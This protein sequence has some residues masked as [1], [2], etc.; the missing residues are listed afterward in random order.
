M[1]T[2][3]DVNPRKRNHD[4][5]A[6]FTENLKSWHIALLYEEPECA[7]LIEFQFI[8]DGLKKGQSCYYVIHGNRE[9][10]ENEMADNDI[11]VKHYLENNF[12]C[13]IESSDIPDDPRGV[14][15][16]ND[17]L[18]M[19]MCANLSVPFRVVGGM[20]IAD[21]ISMVNDSEIA[22]EATSAQLDLEHNFHSKLFNGVQGYWL[23]PYSVNDIKAALNGNNYDKNLIMLKLLKSHDGAVFATKSGKGL[24]VFMP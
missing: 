18:T 2:A 6:I 4:P 19:K 7:R 17:S 14:L 16:A 1:V 10:I 5:L 11:D 15:A 8:K 3:G 9:Y 24:S 22:G 21:A 12:L 13:I 20:S 23:C